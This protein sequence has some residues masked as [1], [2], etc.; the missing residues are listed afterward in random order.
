[1]QNTTQDGDALDK[2]EGFF[3]DLAS[4]LVSQLGIPPS[5]ETRRIWTTSRDQG[6]VHAVSYMF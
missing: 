6:S 2:P 5:R 4:A 3:G 1:V